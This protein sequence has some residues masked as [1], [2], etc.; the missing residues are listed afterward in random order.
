MKTFSEA[1]LESSSLTWMVKGVSFFLLMVLS[2]MV[3]ATDR[4]IILLIRKQQHCQTCLCQSGSSQQL[5]ISGR[6]QRTIPSPTAVN[7]SLLAGS[8]GRTCLQSPSFSRALLIQLT[9]ATFSS[10][11]EQ[12][13]AWSTSSATAS[14]DWSKSEPQTDCLG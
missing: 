9:K 12:T 3:S 1:H 13:A 2:S 11:E 6:Y 8:I 7:R 14:P 5:G 10:S 4:L